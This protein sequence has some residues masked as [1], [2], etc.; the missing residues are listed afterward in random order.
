MNLKP[1]YDYALTFVGVPYLWG[2]TNPLSGLDCSGL[3]QELLAS[4]GQAPPGDQSAQGLY[5]YFSTRPGSSEKGLGALCFYGK[6]TKSI[7]HVMLM[8]DENLCIG[9]NGGGFKT[10]SRFEADRANAFVKVRPFNYRADL[11]AVLFPTYYEPKGCSRPS[12]L[13]GSQP[14]P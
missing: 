7:T 1:L 3:V 14:T 11:V 6:D 2:G 13:F 5:N 10:I 8:L 12:Q 4:I 9:A